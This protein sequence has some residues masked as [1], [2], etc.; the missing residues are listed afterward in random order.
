MDPVREFTRVCP[1]ILTLLASSKV[2]YD[3]PT[4]KRLLDST[5]EPTTSRAPSTLVLFETL[6]FPVM[7]TLLPTLKLERTETLLP[8]LKLERMVTGLENVARPFT[9]MFEFATR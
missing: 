6:K 3:A 2:R 1:E 8:T 5:S 9:V 4:T 7:S